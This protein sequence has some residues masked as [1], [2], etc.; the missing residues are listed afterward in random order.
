MKTSTQMQI[1]R[2]DE[3]EHNIIIIKKE[4]EKNNK[5]SV[6]KRSRSLG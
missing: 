3:I 1:F 4:S 5:T 6:L 2:L